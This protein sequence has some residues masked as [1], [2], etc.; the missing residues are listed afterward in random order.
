[1][2]VR[3]WPGA[4][5][6]QQP[7]GCTISSTAS[8]RGGLSQPQGSGGA[9][10]EQQQRLGCTISSSAFAQGGLSQPHS[11]SGA[12]PPAER[13]PVS[14]LDVKAR[15]STDTSLCAFPPPAAASRHALCE[16]TAPHED[17]AK[18]RGLREVGMLICPPSKAKGQRWRHRTRAGASDA[19]RLR[20]GRTGPTTQ[21]RHRQRRQTGWTE[22]TTAQQRAEWTEAATELNDRSD[23]MYFPFRQAH[24]RG[25]TWFMTT[26]LRLRMFS[27]C[28]MRPH[29]A[30][31][32]QHRPRPGWA[33]PTT[34]VRQS[35]GAT[36]AALR[37]TSSSARGGADRA[38]HTAASEPPSAIEQPAPSGRVGKGAAKPRR[39]VPSGGRG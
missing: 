9:A 28:G 37:T 15:G 33:G 36:A 31:R 6:Q 32:R 2:F 30:D 27:W 25:G 20:Q 38:N 34:R 10:A 26:S 14:T 19:R 23:V 13:F 1:M 29:T 5:E 8:A 18:S 4:A 24:Q 39:S 17:D 21:Q 12:G 35:S 22:P 7:D 3:R 16:L 11:S